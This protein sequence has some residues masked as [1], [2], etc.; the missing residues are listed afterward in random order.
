MGAYAWPT[1]NKGGGIVHA[2]QVPVAIYVLKGGTC[3]TRY[4]QG[5]GDMESG[6]ARISAGQ[7]L[8]GAFEHGRGL[9]CVGGTPPLCAGRWDA[10]GQPEIGKRLRPG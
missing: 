5:V 7:D 6:S 2:V 9:G 3:R 10:W 1:V 8:A 4:C